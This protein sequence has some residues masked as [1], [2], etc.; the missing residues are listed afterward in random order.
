M[1]KKLGKPTEANAKVLASLF[2]AQASMRNKRPLRKFDPEDECIASDF[3]R[4]KK[5]ATPGKVRSKK[6]K[7]VM[8]DVILPIIPKGSRRQS[9][10]KCNRILEIPFLRSMMPEEVNTLICDTFKHLGNVEHFKFLHAQ[11]DH[12]LQVSEVQQLDGAAVIRLA[13]SGCLYLIQE[14]PIDEVSVDQPSTSSSVASNHPGKSQILLDKAEKVLL[15]LQVWCL[16]IV[17]F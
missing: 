9:L 3:H 17:E 4:R 12:T 6:L 2:P 13:G 16:Y 10:M 8:L 11:Q 5:S 14:K 7:V 15:K 1:C